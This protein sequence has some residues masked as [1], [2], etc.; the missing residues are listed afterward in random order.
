MNTIGY[1]NHGYNNNTLKALTYNFL[2]SISY[3]WLLYYTN[4]HFFD[5]IR[6][7]QV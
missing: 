1:N 4:I 3:K 2:D 5:E 6:Y 7:K